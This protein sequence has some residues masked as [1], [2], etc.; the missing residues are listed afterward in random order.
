MAQVAATDH[1]LRAVMLLAAPS[2]YTDLTHWQHRKWGI[3]SEVP[4]TL[5]LHSYGYPNADQRPI[6]V[7]GEI[8]P[9]ALELIGGSNDEVV[10]DYMIHALYAAARPPKSLWIIP[11][12]NH[13]GYA[14]A[15]PVEYPARLVAFFTEHLLATAPER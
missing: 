2:D 14:E 1:R 5:A 8:S 6:D 13:G 3:L 11:G 4:A 7:I 9:R 12:A 10:P 15:S